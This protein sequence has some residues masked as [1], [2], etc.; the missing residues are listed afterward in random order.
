MLTTLRIKKPGRIDRGVELDDTITGLLANNAPVAVGVSGGKDSCAA[1]IAVVD[2]L[3]ATGHNGKV[4]LVHSDLGD[5]DP[6]LDVEW[7]DSLP[8]CERLAAFL[9]VELLVVR[10]PAGG[11]VK[12]WLSR[13][14]ANVERYRTLSCVKV[15]LPWSTPA[16]RFCTSELKSAPIASG[17]V[18]RFPGHRI[19]SACGVRRAESRS[20]ADAVTSKVNDRLENRKANTTGVDW[21]P[22]AAWSESDVYAFCAARGFEMHEGYTKYKM[23]RISCRLCIMQDEEDQRVSA[24]VPAHQPV[25][26]TLVQLEVTSTFGFQGSRW[27]ADVAMSQD[28]AAVAGA[29]ARAEL[30]VRAEA[31]IPD[32]LLYERGW[33]KV[34]PTQAEAEMLAG[35]RKEVAQIMGFEVEYTEPQAIIDRYAFLMAEN[36]RRKAKKAG[37]KRRTK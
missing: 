32:H 10:R 30:R 29:K 12:R 20:R 21:N 11:M 4:I 14:K 18:K 27:L 15:I 6:A 36:E 31:A 8:T 23:K 17:L 25:L 13:W 22:I 37:R 26:R 24:S 7:A 35:V 2:H 5:K 34:M 33:P 3:R 1:A 19:V 9:G 16:M 28:S